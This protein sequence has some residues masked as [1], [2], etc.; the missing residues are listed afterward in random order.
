MIPLAS[1]GL[2]EFFTWGNIGGIVRVVILVIFGFPAAKL[3]A[4]VAG[5]M[6]E[7]R[8]SEQTGMVT[9]K[10]LFYGIIITVLIM[11]LNELGF[12]LS[13]LLGA[14]GI[15]G[16]ALGFASQTSVSNIISGLFLMSEQS[17]KVGDI[18]DVGGTIG[19]VMSVDLLSLKLRTFDNKFVRIPNESLI[20]TEVKNITHFPIRRID[21]DLGVAYKENIS[22]VEEILREIAIQEPDCLDDPEPVFLFKNFGDSALEC[23][24]AVWIVRTDFIKV[25][26][27]IMRRIKERFDEEGIEIP[28]PHRTVYTGSVTTPYPISIVPSETTQSSEQSSV[29]EKAS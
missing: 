5:R 15:L 3:A 22:R 7:K 20:K 17:F 14:A 4:R 24:F 1:L 28:F 8:W 11:V 27:I 25:K 10:L 2:S 9:R 29:E 13:T 18:I 21:I 16:I 23:F 26:N 19:V 12:S 6:A